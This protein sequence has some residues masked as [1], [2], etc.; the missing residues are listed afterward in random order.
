MS[1]MIILHHTKLIRLLGKKTNNIAVLKCVSFVENRCVFPEFRGHIFVIF[2]AMAYTIVMGLWN[3]IFYALSA[4]YEQSCTFTDILCTLCYVDNV[5]EH[6]NKEINIICIV[7]W[8]LLNGFITFL[9][10]GLCD[11]LVYCIDHVQ[12]NSLSKVI[13][14]DDDYK[15]YY[16]LLNV[17]KCQ[18]L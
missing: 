18:Q 16:R 12:R 11:K 2:F 10:Q 7:I 5:Y 14:D 13:S 9:R 17:I 8:Y 4:S 1:F 15:L 6:I 3:L